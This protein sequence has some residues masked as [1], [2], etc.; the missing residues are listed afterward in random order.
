MV[1]ARSAAGRWTAAGWTTAG[2]TTAARGA[3]GLSV[4]LSWAGGPAAAPPAE[5]ASSWRGSTTTWRGRRRKGVDVPKDRSRDSVPS[6]MRC[7]CAVTHTSHGQ[8]R[9][10][11]QPEHTGQRPEES[12]WCWMSSFRHPSVMVWICLRATGTDSA[13]PA[14][15]AISSTA[16]NRSNTARRTQRSNLPT[17]SPPRRPPEGAPTALNDPAHTSSRLKHCSTGL[18]S[19]T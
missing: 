13:A 11:S 12:G 19:R 18:R 3:G 17:S 7:R 9:R 15:V 16:A 8:R 4:P 6:P 10:R 14:W 2:W 5:E 1:P